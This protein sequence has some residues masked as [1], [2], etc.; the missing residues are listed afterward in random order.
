MEIFP[1]DV[2]KDILSRLPVKSLVRFRCVS[3]TWLEF[4]TKDNHFI[5]LHLSRSHHHQPNFIFQTYVYIDCDMNSKIS[6]SKFDCELEIFG[7]CNGL[8]CVTDYFKFYVSN[9]L[10]KDYISIPSPDDVPILIN[11]MSLSVYGFGFDE[12]SND[13]KIFRM[14]TTSTNDKD[15]IYEI[16]SYITVYT[17]GTNSWRTL[18]DMWCEYEIC[19]DQYNAL[20]NGALHWMGTRPGA[21]LN[22]SI[23]RIP[24]LFCFDLKVEA[25]HEIPQPNYLKDKYLYPYNVKVGE[26][27]GLLCLFS[28]LF[29]EN[30]E[31]WAMKEY[32]IAESW[33]KQFKI[34]QLEVPQSFYKLTPVGIYNKGEII[35]N[36]DDRE[37]FLYMPQTNTIRSFMTRKYTKN[38]YAYYGSLISP[39]SF[40]WS[41]T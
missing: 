2:V 41:Q 17:L 7:I 13:Y 25:F 24:V 28:M 30:I 6:E 37:L 5:K 16:Q 21:G 11:N 4:L 31:V 12:S 20:V 23:S 10:T 33:T 38:A 1:R 32:G 14:F 34:T 29:N 40:Q 15:D 18:E 39:T 8:V 36:K 19:G 9:P 22:T 26:L 35:I 27:D 3:K